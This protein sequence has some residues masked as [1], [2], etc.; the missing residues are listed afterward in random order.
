MSIERFLANYPPGITL[1][2]GLDRTRSPEISLVATFARRFAE[3]GS[4]GLRTKSKGLELNEEGAKNL[5]RIGVKD[6]AAVYLGLTIVHIEQSLV[7]RFYSHSNFISDV[8]EA[9]RG[10]LFKLTTEKQAVEEI[11][12]YKWEEMIQAADQDKTLSV[13]ITNHTVLLPPRLNDFLGGRNLFPFIGVLLPDYTVRAQSLLDKQ[14]ARS[15]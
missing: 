15:R 8:Q 9:F 14:P 6:L 1:K 5:I 7:S 3:A 2:E 4:K 13:F 10:T 11:P 12:R